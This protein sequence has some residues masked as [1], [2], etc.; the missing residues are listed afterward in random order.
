MSSKKPDVAVH[1]HD[2]STW[3][4]ESGGQGDQ[5]HPSTQ[6]EKARQRLHTKLTYIKEQYHN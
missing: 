5:G 4:V 6:P 1:T 3:K 2:L